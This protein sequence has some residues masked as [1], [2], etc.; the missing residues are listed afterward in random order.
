MPH[1]LNPIKKK[2]FAPAGV[3]NN[4]LH[5]TTNIAIA[6]SEIEVAQAGRVFVVVS[7]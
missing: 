7:V 3:M 5:N 2:R 1:N 4:L 6:L